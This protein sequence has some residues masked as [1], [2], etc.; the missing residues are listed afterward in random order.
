MLTEAK[1]ELKTMFLSI[2]YNIVREMINPVSFV[3]NVLFM[4]LNN[5]TFI[6]QWV[7]LFTMKDSFGTY[8]IKEICLLWGL[9]SASYGVSRVL[10]GGAF[11]LPKLIEIG[12]LD[13]YLVL[14][15]NTLL[16]VISSHTEISAIGDLLY[17]LIVSFIFF[18]NPIE[19]L[20]ILIFILLAAL[21]ETSF[22]IILNSMAFKYVKIEDFAQSI[23][24]MFTSFSVYPD[25]I[26][27]KGLKVILYTLI[28]VGIATYLPVNTIL[29]F[30]IFNLIIVV[31][32][33]IM[34]MLL[35]YVVFFNGLKRYTSSNLMS[36]R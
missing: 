5:A 3:L 24:G 29:E 2:K 25:S 33:T 13:S 4:M 27:S 21:I 22:A 8:G 10:F 35:A 31:L 17:G 18:H 32:F 1:K 11:T 34:I 19:V 23:L 15:K 6:V 7:I 20:L 36:S 28:P 12:K 16:S 26:F 14:P 9:S 30:N